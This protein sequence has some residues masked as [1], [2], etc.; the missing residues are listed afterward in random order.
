M[1]LRSKQGAQT[2]ADN[3]TFFKAEMMLRV[4][5]EILKHLRER[6]PTVLPPEKGYPPCCT[7]DDQ[8]MTHILAA[9]RGPLEKMYDNVI[10]QREGEYGNHPD[11]HNLLHKATT[12]Q[13]F[14]RSCKHLLKI[15]TDF[16]CDMASVYWTEA[17]MV[18]HAVLFG[19]RKL[20]VIEKLFELEFINRMTPLLKHAFNPLKVE[21]PLDVKFRFQLH[22][23]HVVKIF[24]EDITTKCLLLSD[25]CV[26]EIKAINDSMQAGDREDLSSLRVIA[27]GGNSF[28]C[29]LM[30]NIPMADNFETGVAWELLGTILITFSS[31]RCEKIFVMKIMKEKLKQA[32]IASTSSYKLQ[33]LVIRI[34]DL[35]TL[36]NRCALREFCAHIAL[37][38]GAPQR[39]MKVVE[40]GIL[41]TRS[42][43]TTLVLSRAS[44][45][46][47]L[48]VVVE[49]RAIVYIR[50][51]L[52]I[53]LNATITTNDKQR[54]L[55]TALAV[56]VAANEKGR[57]VA[58]LIELV[59]YYSNSTRVSEQ[60]A[61]PRFA[62][63]LE[64]WRDSGM[65]NMKWQMDF[66]A[67]NRFDNSFWTLTCST[68]M[69][70]IKGFYP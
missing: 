13:G 27:S 21:P 22:L 7:M 5:E 11:Y 59:H 64:A 38:V 58:L 14:F 46:G 62:R 30:T 10:Q 67:N 68:F 63:E 25:C 57:L 40:S 6:F 2:T 33:L 50:A 1:K 29:E 12:N 53:I 55:L 28:L 3:M 24:C 36:A 61:L 65:R 52:E 9:M 17:L 31:Y 8:T 66:Y 23:L 42:F 47:I 51:L 16:A 45:S 44:D 26:E 56:F 15:L 69:H 4:Q 32:V 41:Y 18:I 34:I 20:E 48:H 60:R 70:V 54:F 19:G 39:F 43:I 35:L 49:Q 37:D